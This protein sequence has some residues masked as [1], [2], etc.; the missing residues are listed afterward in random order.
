MFN[1]RVDLNLVVSTNFRADLQTAQGS[2]KVHSDVT[3]G[4]T[5]YKFITK[6]APRGYYGSK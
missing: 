3:K 1:K 4:F 6:E 2:F 5:K